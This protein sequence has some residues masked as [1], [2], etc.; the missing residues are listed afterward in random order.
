MEGRNDGEARRVAEGLAEGR[1]LSHVC[2]TRG[3][4]TICPV[5][6]SRLVPRPICVAGHSVD[7][8]GAMPLL[9]PL[10]AFQL[11]YVTVG[12]LI[13]LRCTSKTN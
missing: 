12:T 8:L 3:H 13:I 7:E 11:R 2:K 4:R 10:L 6:L 9:R 5:R 1:A